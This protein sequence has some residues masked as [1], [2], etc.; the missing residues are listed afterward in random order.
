M[1]DQAWGFLAGETLR[2][3]SRAEGERRDSIAGTAAHPFPVWGAVLGVV[4]RG[5]DW[6][7][8]HVRD[9]ARAVGARPPVHRDIGALHVL[10]V[11]WSDHI[12]HAVPNPAALRVAPTNS[13]LGRLPRLCREH[14]P[15]VRPGDDVAADSAGTTAPT[16][17]R[18]ELHSHPV[19]RPWRCQARCSPEKPRGQNKDTQSG[20]T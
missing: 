10:R 7:V 2:W 13:G 1:R 4:E 17:P 6:K 8:E 5:V 9:D 14:K 3:P 12:G 15:A 11:E 20:E 16:I 18:T 19:L